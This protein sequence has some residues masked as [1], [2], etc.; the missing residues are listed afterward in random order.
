MHWIVLACVIIF[1]SMGQVLFKLSALNYN[2]FG[3]IFDVRVVGVFFLASIV[4]AVS[5]GLWVWLLRYMDISKAYPFMAL[6]FVI[7]PLLSV[8][9]F[10]EKL[11]LPYMVGVS[12]IIAG[13]ALTK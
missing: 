8:W 13:V 3:S 11:S 5:T 1:I 9:L 6:G 4:Y 10:N 12:L 7:V 2:K